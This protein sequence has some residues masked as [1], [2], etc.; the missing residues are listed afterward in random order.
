MYPEFMRAE[1]LQKR[2]S[3]FHWVGKAGLGILVFVATQALIG[4]VLLYVIK[5]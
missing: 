3:R 2:R 5:P 1:L 4:F